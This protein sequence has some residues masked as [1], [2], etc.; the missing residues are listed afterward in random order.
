VASVGVA[1]SGGDDPPA[2]TTTTT[3]ISTTTVPPVTTIVSAEPG[4]AVAEA[5]VSPPVIDGNDDDWNVTTRHETPELVFRNTLIQNGSVARLGTNGTAEVLLGWDNNNLYVFAS[6]QDDIVSQPNA[7]NQIW[8]GDAIT[9]N[10][11]IGDQRATASEDP[12]ANDF[13]VTLSPG[14][15][16]AG[17]SPGSVIF[18]GSSGRFGSDRTG[19]AEVAS[20]FN[21]G[22]SSWML[23]ARIPWQALNVSDPGT[24]G[25]FGLLVALFDND[26]EL[27][28]D[29][30]RSLQTVILGNTPDAVFQAPATW[31]TLTL[32]R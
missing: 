25:P 27:E 28:A 7:G 8:R 18:S 11:A 9:L 23:E 13:Q 2:T 22:D 31:G 24:A 19:L 15:P 30:S 1:L 4:T 32:A 21:A 16:A 5:F 12:D 3:E 20:R 6:V 14:D 17:T 10:I 26:G 29:G